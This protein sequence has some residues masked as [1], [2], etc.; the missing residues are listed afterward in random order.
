MN[1]CDL[2]EPIELNGANGH[3]IFDD[4][5]HH[6]NTIG[7]VKRCEKCDENGQVEIFVECDEH[8]VKK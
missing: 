4:C 3:W 8:A 2:G 7:N 6:A 5:P 1:S